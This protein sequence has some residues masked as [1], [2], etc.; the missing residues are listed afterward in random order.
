[1]SQNFSTKKLFLSLFVVS[2]ALAVF[3]IV[4]FNFSSQDRPPTLGPDAKLQALIKSGEYQFLKWE[5]EDQQAYD[6][7]KAGFIADDIEATEIKQGVN[8]L[9]SDED[10]TFKEAF[11]RVDPQ[12]QEGVIATYSPQE[13]K[14]L[15]YPKTTYYDPDATIEV[16][17]EEA[18]IPAGTGYFLII[19]HDSEGYGFKTGSK[20][21]TLEDVSI[22]DDTEGW[23]L[24][25]S[26][27]G[28]LNALLSDCARD[29]K[30]VFAQ[31]D[32]TSFEKIPID[33]V[34]NYELDDYYLV[35]F[36]T[37]DEGP[38]TCNEPDQAL[39]DIY[40]NIGKREFKAA[41]LSLPPSYQ[42]KIQTQ[43]APKLK[44]I[45]EAYNT[46]EAAPKLALDANGLANIVNNDA[47]YN[48]IIDLL[49]P[50]VR[51]GPTGLDSRENFREDL[52]GVF[53]FTNTAGQWAAELASED[54]IEMSQFFADLGSFALEA[55]EIFEPFYEDFVDLQYYR[56]LFHSLDFF[57]TIET[58]IKEEVDEDTVIVTATAD[59][60]AALDEDDS[61][62]MD[63]TMK[64]ILEDDCYYWVIDGLDEGIDAWEDQLANHAITIVAEYTAA[65]KTATGELLDKIAE[66]ITTYQSDN[67]SCEFFGN[68]IIAINDYFN[69]VYDRETI[70]ELDSL[71][72]P[73]NTSFTVSSPEGQDLNA[74]GIHGAWEDESY[75]SDT[76]YIGED[77]LFFT[78]TNAAGEQNATIIC[79]NITAE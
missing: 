14:F 36:K 74:N 48:E 11:L 29:V 34:Q 17:P 35:W 75:G 59:P 13:N 54:T 73:V 41:Y 60:E 55:E 79:I 44:D 70:M 71:T 5:Q 64:R 51:E 56:D 50:E 31:K 58:E 16:D 52:A 24:I 67:E 4:F 68:S 19:T 8:Y 37:K 53:A 1:M 61:T 39:K 3:G 40:F 78:G 32:D 33:D 18:I 12:A 30:T 62:E 43:I 77:R 26:N 47:K 2:L 57:A 46:V 38:A 6:E 49:P 9:Y 72:T 76:D 66:V 10:L 23:N 42:A 21:S 45:L 20:I 63:F 28:N 15:I 69:V 27:N 22:C 7:I 25:A 65:L